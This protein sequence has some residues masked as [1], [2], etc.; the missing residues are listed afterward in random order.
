MKMSLKASRR[1]GRDGFVLRVKPSFRL[2]G[3]AT[4]QLPYIVDYD[5]NRIPDKMVHYDCSGIQDEKGN[6]DWDGNQDKMG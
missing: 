4:F 2:I 1:N 5:C 6:Y 3:G